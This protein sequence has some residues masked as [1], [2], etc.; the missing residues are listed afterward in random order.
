[1]L[2]LQYGPY[3]CARHAATKQS[4]KAHGY[5]YEHTKEH[6]AGNQ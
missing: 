1:M 3:S 5:A 2:S 4:E 6:A